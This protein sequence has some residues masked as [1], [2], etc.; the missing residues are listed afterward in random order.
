[1]AGSLCSSLCRGGCQT[2]PQ[3]SPI[4]SVI[5][6][7]SDTQLQTSSASK[8]LHYSAS[9][10]EPVSVHCSHLQQTHVTKLVT[11]QS[12]WGLGTKVLTQHS[13]GRS[14]VRK[15][16]FLSPLNKQQIICFPSI[17]TEALFSTLFST[18][19]DQSQIS[20]TDG[21]SLLSSNVSKTHPHKQEQTHTYR[22]R[23]TSSQN[24]KV[25]S[26]R[27]TTSPQAGIAQSPSVLSGRV[28]KHTFPIQTFC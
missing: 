1:M 7:L 16:H 3:C 15:S 11:E 27:S 9:P 22:P 19:A 18:C 17:S 26:K 13:Q 4:L 6:P 12:C 2:F 20:Q 23:R 8:A 10:S 5:K 24:S 21:E 25:K 28:S 14:L